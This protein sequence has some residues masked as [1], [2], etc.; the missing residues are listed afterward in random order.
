MTLDYCYIYIIC[1]NNRCLK[2]ILKSKISQVKYYTEVNKLN[3]VDI[4]QA[5]SQSRFRHFQIAAALGLTE[6]AF[7]KKLRQ[8]LPEEEKE[9]IIKA[10]IKMKEAN[11]E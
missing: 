2:D 3:N 1:N 6:T 9:K 5:I 11:Y 8:E 7:S 4:R 10:I